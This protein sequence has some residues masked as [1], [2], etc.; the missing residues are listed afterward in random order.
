MIK[1]EEA[2]NIINNFSL[3]H[4]HSEEVG[5]ENSVNR[6]LAEDVVSD[7]DF[8]S[9]NK[10]AMD[11]YAIRSEEIGKKLRVIEFIPAGKKPEKTVESGCCSKIM[12]GAMLP[13]GAD[14]VVMQEDVVADGDFILM[15]NLKSRSNILFQAEDLKQGTEILKKGIIINPVHV[16]LLASVGKARPLVYKKPRIAIISTGNE[17]VSP[18]EIP[19]PPKIR[20]SN[21]VQLLSL[22]N[23]LGAQ[24]KNYSQ[25]EDSE[26]LILE[27]VKN[28]METSDIVVL[29][30]GA[31][32]GD[33][34]F[35]AEVFNRLNAE[36]HFTRLAI[37]PGKP[38][39][40]ATKG[41]KFL[42]GLSGNPVSSFVQF[43]LLVK[44]L[45]QNLTGNI[46]DSKILSLPIST[47]KRRKKSERML[48]FPVRINENMEAEPLDYHG[49]AHLNAYQN[50]NAMASF[51]IGVNELQKGTKVDVRPI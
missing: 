14:M 48:F 4:L 9:F 51:P 18:N 28:A 38:V 12:T 17:L 26:D 40:F 3:V 8:P 5:L 10:S 34:D 37:Q 33:Y 29:T 43:Q 30:G 21:S 20:N 22:S 47:D 42:F 6:V 44:P 36:T 13:E 49:S 16:G 25:V 11:G 15:E 46:S 1:L 23:I 27:A 31:S 39:L 45:L 50:A 2:L 19:I 32:V 35:T 41:K 7:M 24:A